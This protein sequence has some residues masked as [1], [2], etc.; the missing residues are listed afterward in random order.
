MIEGFYDFWG[1]D[2]CSSWFYF[3]WGGSIGVLSREE[4]DLIEVFI[5]LVGG[6]V[7][8]DCGVFV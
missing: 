6:W 4:G 7:E 5:R 1:L 2:F 3:E 8:L